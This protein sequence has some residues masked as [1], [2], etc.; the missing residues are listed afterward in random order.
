M[1]WRDELTPDEA[2]DL[3][4]LESQLRGGYNET[5]ELAR[6]QIMAKVHARATRRNRIE[7]GECND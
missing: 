2:T 1:G 3:Q 6:R 5:L 7:Q 4:A